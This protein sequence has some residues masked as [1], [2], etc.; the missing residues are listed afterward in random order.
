ML[1]NQVTILKYQLLRNFVFLESTLREET[2]YIPRK[3]S[4]YRKN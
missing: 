1:K 3:F 2:T 4:K